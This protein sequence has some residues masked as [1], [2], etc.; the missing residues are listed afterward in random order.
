MAY[1]RLVALLIAVF[2][3]QN[4]GMDAA[5]SSAEGSQIRQIPGRAVAGRFQSRIDSLPSGLRTTAEA[6]VSGNNP[7][8][9]RRLIETMTDSSLPSVSDLF[10]ELL[11]TETVASVRLDLLEYLTR[12]PRPN[13]QPVFERLAKSDPD[14]AVA[15]VAIEGVRAI[16]V[17]KVKDLLNQRLEQSRSD[18]AGFAKFVAAEER[19]ISLVRG[20]MLPGFLRVPPPVFTTKQ[21]TSIRVVALGDF[22][23][24]T[25]EQKQVAAAML[26]NHR[27]SP[28]DIGVTVGDNFYPVGMESPKDKRWKSWWEQLYAPLQI[29]FYPVLGNHDWYDFDSPAAEILYSDDSKIWRMPSPY[30]TYIA[31][32]VQFFAIDTNDVSIKQLQ[33]LDSELKKSRATW[34]VVYGHHPIYSDG[35]HGDNSRVKEQLLPLLKNRVDLYLA[36]HEHDL[37]HLKPEAGVHFVVTG[38][39][40]RELRTPQPTSRALFAKEAHGF[41]ILEV[42]QS[43]FDIRFVGADSKTLHEFSFQK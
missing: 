28:F 7:L 42:S 43:R 40:G 2:L 34:K 3:V 27:Q 35:Y 1:I 20:V 36:G 31:G 33:W 29:A 18:P 5:L 21:Q 41:T 38:G 6:L 26:A 19:W 22:G 15:I 23:T 16:E 17:L 30:Y 14:P 9:K 10:V 12:N 32:P 25:D 4:H 37:Q 39:G 11:E 13:L 8:E 24:G